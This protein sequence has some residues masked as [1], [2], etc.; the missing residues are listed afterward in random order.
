MFMSEIASEL[1]P[2]PRR[3]R[4]QQ[5]AP[6]PV[7]TEEILP[8]RPQSKKRGVQRVIGLGP[9]G[10]VT[11]SFG[12]VYSQALRKGDLVRTRDG[13][14]APIT[15]VRHVKL[16]ADFLSY[17]PGV[18]P[19]VIPARSLNGKVPQTDLKVAP[20]QRISGGQTFSGAEGVLAVD[21]LG[22]GRAMRLTESL[23]T[24]T[25]LEFDRPVSISLEGI[26]VDVG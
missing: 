19:L 12:E 2:K 16:D 7:K 15:R 18:Q 1:D 14:L 3:F 24:Y 6:Q 9:M 17:H 8:K 25:I 13:R 10:R 20:H 4:I 22:R 23:F 5:P 11:T 21:L 26:W